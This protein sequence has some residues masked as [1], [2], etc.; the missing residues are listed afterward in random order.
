MSNELILLQPTV[1]YGLWKV[2]PLV[3]LSLL[4]LLLAWT[5]APVFMTCS[6]TVMLF[7]IGKITWIRSHRY[8]ITMDYVRFS[9]GFLF[10]RTDQVELYRIRDY[11]VTQSFPM[12]LFGLMKLTLKGTDREGPVIDIPGIPVSDIVDELCDRVQAARLKN[13]IIEIN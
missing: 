13:N 9:R 10:K 7:V 4:F 5:L 1:S 12:Q 6:L 11:V 2:V 8:L 3:A